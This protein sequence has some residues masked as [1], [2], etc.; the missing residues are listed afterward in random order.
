MPRLKQGH[1]DKRGYYSALLWIIVVRVTFGFHR[2]VSELSNNVEGL[3]K[4]LKLNLQTIPRYAEIAAW[5][6]TISCLKHSTKIAATLGRSLN[7][8]AA[9]RALS[10]AHIQQ[11]LWTVWYSHARLWMQWLQSKFLFSNKRPVAHTLKAC[12]TFGEHA[13]AL[14]LPPRLYRYLTST[15][16]GGC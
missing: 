10:L 8:F 13:E 9:W 4:H 7:T 6:G 12:G 2:L 1:R 14:S 3:A 16:L 5:I 11:P 15:G